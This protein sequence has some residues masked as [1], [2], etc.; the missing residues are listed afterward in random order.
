MAAPPLLSLQEAS[1][2]F[3]GGPLFSEVSFN[4]SRG[5]K[6][7][8]VGRNG[9]GK[10]TLLKILAGEVDIDQGV[11]FVQPGL[12]LAYMAQEPP[13]NP[14]QTVFDF[15]AA[16]LP[17]DQ[18]DQQHRIAPVLEPFGLSAERSLES[19]SGGE[20]RRSALARALIA[21]PDVLLLDE[22]TNH[23]DIRAIEWLE[24]HLA[25]WRGALVVVSHDRAFLTAVSNSVLWLDR[26][27][28]QRLDKGFADFD[29]W[30]ADFR[31]RE[32]ES[33]HRLAM[34]IK[35]EEDWLRYGVT[36]RRKRNQGRLARLHA[37][38][39]RRRDFV[40]APGTAALA[41]AHAGVSGK[42]VIEAQEITKSFPDDTGG[43]K[44]VLLPFSTRIT[45][46]DRLGIIGP[47]GAGKTTLLRLLIG[48]LEPDSGQVK[49]GTRLEPIYF[50][51]RRESLDP[52]ASI[53]QTLVP[54]GGDSLMVRGRQRHVVS[55]LKD[56]LFEEKQARQPVKS[57]S[58]G[59]KNRLLL[60]RL[61]AR[62][63]NLLILDEPTNDLDL[64]T[65]DLLV[66]TVDA[67]P[68]PL[69]LVSHDRDLIDRLAS[70]VIALEGDGKAIDYPGGYSDYLRQRK[71]SVIA[72]G[73]SK[74][75][76]K[77]KPQAPKADRKA[78]KLSYKDSR[79]LSRLP[80]EIEG[81]TEEIAALEEILSDTELFSRDPERFAKISR[82]FEQKK[83]ALD[84][85]ETRWLELESLR[86]ELAGADEA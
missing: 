53:W 11:R 56:F 52:E 18:A 61:F 45:R 32:A 75:S 85:A 44:V 20:E 62:P 42:S 9:S 12:R 33:Q 8:L 63:G 6:L 13:K 71:A 15:V 68:G 25:T 34:E 26:G 3:G 35:R 83:Q 59:E 58:G 4:L 27:C 77:T 60:A 46:D 38:R 67:F 28:V 54:G 50:D 17:R 84:A 10:S 47:N 19:L 14:K 70:G 79:E 66:E 69:L 23:L 41:L 55:Y 22:P 64:E 31:R 2:T 78:T 43:K 24:S 48:D 65:L 51:Q 49:L 74:Q 73:D 76:R 29:D 82:A 36:A 5:D 16:G 7:C 1:L 39:D 81:L 37:L 72:E 86:E 30:A 80:G 40:R 21:E 57:L